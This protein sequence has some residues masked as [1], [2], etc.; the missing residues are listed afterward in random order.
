[1]IDNDLAK[2]LGKLSINTFHKY[3]MTDLKDQLLEMLKNHN[4]LTE[5]DLQSVVWMLLRDFIKKSDSKPER[6]KVHNQIYLKDIGMY[7]DII[8]FRKNI[9]WII[10]E[11]KEKHHLKI[12]TVETERKYLLEMKK[13][14][15]KLHKTY[16]LFVVRKGKGTGKI[17]DGPKG[18]GSRFFFEIPILLSKAMPLKEDRDK[19]ERERKKLANYRITKKK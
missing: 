19:W 5:A 6:F 2:P 4:I 14:F 8:I 7:P 18:K 10:I 11:L 3:L 17:I 15:K 16:L 13:K 1:M 12:K 9:P